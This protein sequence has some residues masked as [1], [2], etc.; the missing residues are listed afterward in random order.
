[1]IGGGI[2]GLAAARRLK[3]EGAS[4]VVL[5]ARD[6]LGGRIHTQ[7]LVR[8]GVVDLGA[9]FIGDAQRR[10]SA[11]VDEARL[12]RV[13]P[14][15]DGDSLYRSAAGGKSKPQRID[16]GALPLSWLGQLD[17]Y[18]A[19]ERLGH[20]ALT[21]PAERARLDAIT[22]S[23]FIA[24]QTFTSATSDFLRGYLESEY[25]A[26]GDEISALE[27]L[28]Q[29]SSIGG[30]AGEQASAQWF[31]AEGT[32]PLIQHLADDL[33]ASIALQ[34][35]VIGLAQQADRML[36]ETPQGS[37]A[38]RQVIV[39][40]PPQL[41]GRMRLTPW[42]S[43]MQQTVVSAYRQGT[44]IKTLLVFAKPWWRELGL[45][46]GAGSAGGLFNAMVDASPADS[47]VGILVLFSTGP[48]G[49]RLA[50]TRSE[51]ARISLALEDLRTLAV[52]TPSPFFAR[53]VDWND[54]PWSLGGYASRRGPGGWVQAP[55]LFQSRGCLHFAGT[56]TA[57]EW[58]SFMEGA[59]QSAERAAEA[60]LGQLG[61]G[62]RAARDGLHKPRGNQ[63]PDDLS[64]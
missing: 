19:T 25:C 35:P 52:N 57:D 27:M 30:F 4:V 64:G 43:A 7:P 46:G 9:Q 34:A 55:D 23:A 21:E 13:K 14:H 58:R 22:A 47:S 40:V 44:V 33:R 62:D 26:A 54:D 36:V 39:A 53:S 49:R 31:L 63:L 59:L 45:S 24:D 18:Q 5:E 10:I 20:Q 3:Q 37:L 28:D 60:A 11:L 42:L 15:Q 56:E 29:L 50:A 32:G 8:G 61:A 16:P 41:Y 12:T 17:A 51:A 6:R 2:A 1:V 48:S 38:A